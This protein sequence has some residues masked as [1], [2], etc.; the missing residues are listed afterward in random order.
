MGEREWNLIFNFY[1]NCYNINQIR[2]RNKNHLSINI[3]FFDKSIMRIHMVV[4][5]GERGKHYIDTHG[6]RTRE[7]SKGNEH[8]VVGHE[9]ERRETN[10]WW[11]V[12]GKK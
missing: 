3:T 4:G 10:I 2:K 9:R 11:S 1:I 12:T 8:M 7:R 5:H 6:G